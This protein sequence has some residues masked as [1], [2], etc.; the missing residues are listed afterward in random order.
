MNTY[1]LTRWTARRMPCSLT[2]HRWL[3]FSQ[4]QCPL[5]YR[6]C[7]RCGATDHVCNRAGEY[8]RSRIIERDKS[9][10]GEVLFVVMGACA[11]VWVVGLKLAGVI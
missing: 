9:S 5:E 8:L 6:A 3:S 1:P 11:A 2:G 7:S 10:K 4:E